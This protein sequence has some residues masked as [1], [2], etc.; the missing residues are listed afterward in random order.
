MSAGS[1]LPTTK[2]T[3]ASAL[4]H[5]RPN[6]PQTGWAW[7]GGLVFVLFFGAGRAGI[8]A[9]GFRIAVDQFDHRH[10]RVVAIAKPG[11]DDARIAAGPADIPFGQGRHQLVGQMR[12]LQLGDRPAPVR[13]PAMFAERD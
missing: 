3:T 5:S 7:S 1:K 2:T 12:I 10:R 6:S 8:F 13:E 4:S 11:L 9:L